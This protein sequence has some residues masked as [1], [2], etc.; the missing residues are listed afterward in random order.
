MPI[1]NGMPVGA[2][3]YFLDKEPPSPAGGTLAVAEILP[4]LPSAP[5]DKWH[6]PELHLST[7]S[8]P[9]SLE[10]WKEPEEETV[11]LVATSTPQD[12]PLFLGEL[13]S[14]Y[15]GMRTERL[16]HAVPPWLQKVKECCQQG[17]GLFM[18]DYEQDHALPFCAWD[19][20]QPRRLVE[21][22]I[23]M[24]AATP[25]GIWMQIAYCAYNWSTFAEE[26]SVKMQTYVEMIEQ[27]IDVPK[28]ARGP[29]VP[30]GGGILP[31][32][33][34]PL[35]KVVM[36]HQD[37]PLKG[38]TLHEHGMQIAREY[39][40]KGQKQGMIAVVRGAILSAQPPEQFCTVHVRPS[41]DCLALYSY[42]DMRF[43]KWMIAR[44]L[45]DPT[46]LLTL[47]AQ[48]G[49]M[50]EWR[51]WNQRKDGTVEEGE[52]KR[53][54]IPALCLTPE[55]LPLLVHLPTSP[56]LPIRYT[57]GTRLPQIA[58]GTQAPAG[59]GGEAGDDWIVLGEI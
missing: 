54:L 13:S 16:N 43:M 42:Q 9:R 58:G 35:P 56:N 46:E 20:L 39:F 4:P 40:Q 45:P 47:H 17:Y 15:P 50:T 38:T 10:L 59:G 51:A 49:F 24:C 19:P 23:R 25:G 28:F 14:A 53:E 48:G 52:G 31:R 29:S 6:R 1:V 12:L 11:R 18:I 21:D 7:L 3:V 26:G 22:T 34:I 37:H 33:S 8:T 41:Y 36:E 55:E 32:V 30:L 44:A 57:R 5:E 2:F 27:G